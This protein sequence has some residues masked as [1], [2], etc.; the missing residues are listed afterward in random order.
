M[1]NSFSST[2]MIS[3]KCKTCHR[4]PYKPASRFQDVQL[5]TTFPRLYFFEKGYSIRLWR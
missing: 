2:C 1:Q 4:M 3:N 5:A